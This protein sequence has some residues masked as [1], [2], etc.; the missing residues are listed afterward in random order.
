M[1]EGG[2]PAQN[3]AQNETPSRAGDY[4][5]YRWGKCAHGHYQGKYDV[6]TLRFGHFYVT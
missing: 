1:M 6:S 3:I 2:D 5:R 4:R